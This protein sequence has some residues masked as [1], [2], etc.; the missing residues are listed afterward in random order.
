MKNVN[1]LVIII[2]FKNLMTYL[3]IKE[4]INII[5]TTLFNNCFKK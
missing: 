4:I 2:Y 3:N 1:Y 5:K